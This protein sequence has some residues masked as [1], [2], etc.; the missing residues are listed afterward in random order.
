MTLGDKNP[1]ESR[2][3]LRAERIKITLGG[4]DTAHELWQRI[5][6]SEWRDLVQILRTVINRCLRGIRNFGIVPSLHSLR[7]NPNENAEAILRTWRAEVEANGDWQK[8]LPEV[9]LFALGTLLS[10][11]SPTVPSE[12]DVVRWSSI[13]EAIQDDLEPP[14][15]LEFT[16]NA[17][18]HLRLG[19][20]RFSLLEAIIGLEIVLTRWL[21]VYLTAEKGLSKTRIRQFLS[22]DLG[23]GARLAAVLDLTLDRRT[24]KTIDLTKVLSA[25]RWRNH[26]VHRTGK[27]PDDLSEELIRDSIAKVLVLIG[28]LA[29]TT[30]KL[31]QKLAM[32][33]L[34]DQIKA[35]SDDLPR[36]VVSYWGHHRVSVHFVGFG[37]DDGWIPPESD[38]AALAKKIEDI[39]VATD[40]RFRSELH[41][42]IEFRRFPNEARASWDRGTFEKVM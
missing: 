8:L 34:P 10:T 40:A 29:L 21:T 22:P 42:R 28:V 25:V 6:N 17:I 38:V 18:E 5:G 39:R 36:P 31:E 2:C 23:L 32:D 26:V 11:T 33:A 30:E 7:E 16:T 3:F 35:T 19:N 37:T 27:L 20:Q 1:P 24:L 4:D 13:E 9:V 12:L 15:E 41:L 14:P